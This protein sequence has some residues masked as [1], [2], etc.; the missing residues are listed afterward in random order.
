MWKVPPK[1][2][3]CPEVDGK[4]SLI[5]RVVHS[6]VPGLHSI[7]PELVAPPW[8][9][10]HKFGFI[11][12]RV[13]AMHRHRL[14]RAYENDRTFR[15]HSGQRDVISSVIIP[16]ELRTLHEKNFVLIPARYFHH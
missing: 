11:R 9:A 10:A 3:H 5:H 14:D 7:Q 2:G 4:R 16:T 15:Q 12:D 13:G 1:M 8:A 6:A